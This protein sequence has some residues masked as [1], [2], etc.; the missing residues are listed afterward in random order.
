MEAERIKTLRAANTVEATV[1]RTS[2]R[3]V[4][5]EEPV[6]ARILRKAEEPTTVVEVVAADAAAGA[7]EAAVQPHFTSTFGPGNTKARG[8]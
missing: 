6:T 2:A 7:R 1:E 3:R 5:A 8:K 4:S